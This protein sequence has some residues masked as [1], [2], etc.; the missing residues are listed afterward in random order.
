MLELLPQH[1]A[2]RLDELDALEDVSEVKQLDVAEVVEAR[3]VARPDEV[4]LISR[5]EHVQQEVET[6]SHLENVVK[7]QERLQV[8]RS[9]MLHQSGKNC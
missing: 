4:P 6:R 2:K 3:H 9:A 5:S 7:C 8:E 1:E